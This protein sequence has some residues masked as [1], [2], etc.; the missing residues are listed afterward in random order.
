MQWLAKVAVLGSATGWLA[1]W[2]P[3]LK[4]KYS[5]APSDSFQGN[6]YDNSRE[7]DDFV[8]VENIGKP[9]NSFRQLARGLR[10]K[11]NIMWYPF[12]N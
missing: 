12:V 4:V 7:G 8:Y 6:L 5:S 11:H 3:D 1:G 2:V 10:T 9:E